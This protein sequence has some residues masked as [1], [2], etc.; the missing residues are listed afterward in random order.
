MGGNSG[1]STLKE[2]GGQGPSEKEVRFLS[3][4]PFVLL[5]CLNGKGLPG[6]PG[7]LF[8]GLLCAILVV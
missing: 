3:P 4:Q 7:G 6:F 2:L 1:S 5:G 8:F